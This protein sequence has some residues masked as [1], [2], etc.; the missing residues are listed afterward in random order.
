MKDV[1]HPREFF[2]FIGAEIL[3]MECWDPELRNDLLVWALE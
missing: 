2:K 1:Y 3:G